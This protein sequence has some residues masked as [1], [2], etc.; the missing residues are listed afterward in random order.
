MENYRDRLYQRMQI[1]SPERILLMV[2]F[3]RD[4]Y[5][6]RPISQSHHSLEKRLYQY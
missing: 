4:A 6:E 5:G 1:W 2:V 3:V